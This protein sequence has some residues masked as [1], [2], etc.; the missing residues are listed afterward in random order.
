MSKKIL[1]GVAI[2]L[3]IVIVIVFAINL[4]K[5]KNVEGTLQEI[6]AKVYEGINES[7]LPM[8]MRNTELT[9]ENIEYFIGTSDIDFK[10]A[11][12]SESAVTTIAHSVILIRLND[13]K[14]AEE[15]IAK[16]KEN[17]DSKNLSYAEISNVVVKS[18]GDLVILIMSNEELTP[19]LEANFDGLE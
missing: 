15:V 16:I 11:L 5:G 4:S 10:E 13:A 18:K 9:K 12:A 8:M 7:E 14:Q 1:I 3:A 17:V 2:V 6:M 19:R